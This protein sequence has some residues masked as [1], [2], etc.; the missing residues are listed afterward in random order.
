MVVVFQWA[1][2]LGLNKK[3]SSITV[4]MYEEAA[5]V[6]LGPRQNNSD[7]LKK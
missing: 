6:Q 5:G 1:R 4:T 2:G 7:N 3:D